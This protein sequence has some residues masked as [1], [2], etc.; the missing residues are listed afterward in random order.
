MLFRSV[1]EEITEPKGWQLIA[2]VPDH[3]HYVPL[4][5]VVAPVGLDGVGAFVFVGH[6]KWGVRPYKWEV[7]HSRRWSAELITPH[8]IRLVDVAVAEVELAAEVLCKA[9]DPD[10]V[11]S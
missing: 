5:G 8:C 9:T 1:I 6:C 7:V 10:V 3:R 2:A 4:A 11:E